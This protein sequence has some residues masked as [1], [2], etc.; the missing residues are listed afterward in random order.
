M[1]RTSI[2]QFLLGQVLF[3]VKGAVF[4]DYLWGVRFQINKKYGVYYMFDA[5]T[6]AFDKTRSIY[7]WE[8]W[9]RFRETFIIKYILSAIFLNGL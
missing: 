9:V 5:Q 4:Q 1:T 7:I 3:N 2:T 8:F 6:V